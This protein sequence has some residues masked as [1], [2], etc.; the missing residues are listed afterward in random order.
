[1]DRKKYIELVDALRAIYQ[2]NDFINTE[3]DVAMRCAVNSR[4]IIKAFTFSYFAN[5]LSLSLMPAILY[6]I[7]H[8][9]RPIIYFRLLGIAD[10]STTIGLGLNNLTGTSAILSTVL[11][12]IVFDGL[13]AVLA[14]NVNLYSGLIAHQCRKIN[15]LLR[16]ERTA[17]DRVRIR[18]LFRNMIR[19]H[20]EMKE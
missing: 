11:L 3:C 8:E 17:M 14:Y 6:A 19:M 16:D 4:R 5:G 7:T 18:I 13:Y 1:M 2:R 15:E 9:Y 10:S 12:H 20:I